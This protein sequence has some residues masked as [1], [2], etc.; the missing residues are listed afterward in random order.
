M[1]DSDFQVFVVGVNW[2]LGEKCCINC[3]N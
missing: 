1:G 2:E 3:I